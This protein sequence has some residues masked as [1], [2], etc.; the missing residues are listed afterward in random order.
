LNNRSVVTALDAFLRLHACAASRVLVAFSGGPDSTAL[1]KAL[2]ELGEGAVPL[3][4]CWIDHGIRPAEELAAEEAFVRGLAARLG[5]TLHVRRAER[6]SLEARAAELGSLE[7]AA[8]HFRYGALRAVKEA[9][10]LRYILTGHHADDQ[11]ETQVMRFFSGSGSAGLRGMRAEYRDIGRPFLRLR[12]AQLE[13]YLLECGLPLNQD[14]TNAAND[15]LRN[16]LRHELMPVIASL[17][18]GYGTGLNAL[19][20]KLH[21]DDCALAAYAAELFP[22]RDPSRGISLARYKA[23]PRA[24]R[25]R[26]L[27]ALADAALRTLTPGGAAPGQRV[28]W[29]LIAD[30]DGKLERSGDEAAGIA[31]AS[32][33]G[34]IFRL[35]GGAV[36]AG[37]VSAGAA[38]AGPAGFCLA[39]GEP[40]TFRIGKGASCTVYYRDDGEGVRLDAFSWPL[41]LRSRKP[42]DRIRN[43]VGWKALDKLLAESGLPP[44]ARK[45]APV[46]E[47]GSGIVALLAA[48]LGYKDV[49]RYNADL[50]TRASPGYLGIAMKGI[51]EDYAA[52]R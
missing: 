16:K 51:A 50:I 14:S 41:V 29:R 42:G 38:E 11:W 2:A 36:S 32:W 12:R 45:L 35:E 5:V 30:I 33:Q 49:Y 13:S 4:A 23:A 7:A 21:D 46:L 10:G 15:Y 19:S 9:Q 28:P 47:D 52:R 22:E 39:L 34:L 8:R 37:S 25:H 44:E 17:F 1:L 40:G 48:S 27:F 18:P 24:V 26:A 3:H 43:A 20:Q 31:L 6:G